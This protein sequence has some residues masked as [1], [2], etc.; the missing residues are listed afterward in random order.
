MVNIGNLRE[1]Q[2]GARDLIYGAPHADT[3]GQAYVSRESTL[4]KLRFPDH[5]A[6]I[7]K[8][9]SYHMSN[10]ALIFSPHS[11]S[12]EEV[13]LKQLVMFTYAQISCEKYES[14]S[15]LPAKG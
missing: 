10:H 2:S 4:L 15:F 14:I 5:H 7:F 12:K 9:R 1:H 8:A 11:I 6:Y 3:K 13:P